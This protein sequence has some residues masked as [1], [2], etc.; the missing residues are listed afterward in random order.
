MRIVD[1]MPYGDGVLPVDCYSLTDFHEF[2]RCQFSFFVKHHLGKKYE[3]AEGTG[4]EPLAL[5]SLLDEAIK[6]FHSSKAYGCEPDYIDNLIKASCNHLL[7]KISKQ[8][9]LSFYSNIETFLTDELCGKAARVFK[10]YYTGVGQKIKRSIAPVGFCEWAIKSVDP[11]TGSER[12]F[13]V[14]GGPD[15]LELGED[16]LPEIVD[17]KSR[18][19]VEKGKDGMDMELMPKVYT[20]LCAQKLLD[21]GYKRA[22]FVVRFWQDPKE[23]GFFEEFDLEGIKNFEIELKR[24]IEVIGQVS[25]IKFCGKPYCKACK[26]AKRSEYILELQKLGLAVILPVSTAKPTIDIAG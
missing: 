4:S 6:T 10:D 16:G 8:K 2:Q 14:W 20:L 24:K 11:L 3:L 23:D 17:Y 9:G 19:D 1:G 15:A 18:E 22:R 25:E 7:E 5:G 26:A 12:M 21:L 13:K